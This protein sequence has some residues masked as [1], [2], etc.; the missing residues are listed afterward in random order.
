[1]KLVAVEGDVDIASDAHDPPSG[2]GPKPI[3]PV[4]QQNFAR[5]NNLLIVTKGEEFPCHCTSGYAGQLSACSLVWN[6][7]ETPVCREG[8]VSKDGPHSFSGII[9]SNQGFVLSK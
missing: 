8:D 5:I 3:T 1:M 6:I 9:T 4:T 7:N 2:G